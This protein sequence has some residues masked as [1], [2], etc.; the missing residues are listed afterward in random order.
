MGARKDQRKHEFQTKCFK[1]V[2]II[3]HCYGGYFKINGFN[4]HFYS[5]DGIFNLEQSSFRREGVHTSAHN[6]FIMITVKV[7]VEEHAKT[8][9]IVVF[10]FILLK[11][12]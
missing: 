7:F 12:F 2:Y 4:T 9:S 11:L 6:M 5:L 3:K 8:K 10:L 1:F